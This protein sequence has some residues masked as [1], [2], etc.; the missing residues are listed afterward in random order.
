MLRTRLITGAAVGAVALLALTACA[1][2]D[3][4]SAGAPAGVETAE[5]VT[6]T[7]AGTAPVDTVT[8]SIVE[9]E[10]ATLDPASSANLIIPNLCDNL[11]AL[12]PDFSVEPGVAIRAEWTDPT[13]FVIELRD[14]VTFWDGTPLTA[15]DV[16]YSLDRNRSPE[17]QWF[18]A[19]ALVNGIEATGDHEV[20]V[21]FNAPD[22]TFRDALAGGGGAV[23]SAAFGAEAG[24]NLGT[25]DGGLMCTGPYELAA[26]GWTPGNEIVTTANPDYWNGS[27]LVSTLTY[28]FVSDA[29]TLAT[30]LT[31]GE[32]HGALNVSPSSRAA[33][34]GDGAGSLIVGPSTASY[35]FGPAT[36]DGPAA[37]PEIRRAL[38]LAIDRQQYID[39]VLSGLGE[40]Q[41]TIVPPFTFHE[42]A[43]ADV[44][45]A[46]Y[47]ALEAPEVDL[48]AAKQLVDG[49]GEDL[50]APLVL[51]V[52]AGATEFKNTAQIVQSAAKQI[53]VEI[54]INEMQASDFGA[55]FY[56][57]AAREGIDFVATQGYLETPGV[58][59]YPSL[60]MLPE[61]LGGVF[62]WSGYAN[63]EV[64]AHMQAARTATDEQTAAEEFVAA[65]Q[66]FA[67]DMLQVTLAGAYQLSYVNDELTGITTSVAVY[68]S[69]WALHL[70]GQ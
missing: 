3:S 44:Y 25:S 53:G 54:E 59:G 30:A 31:Q 66:I 17:S 18:A 39:T 63:D 49:S 36:P 67:P 46:G 51:A 43:A 23:M 62:N 10:P 61:E 27:P 35:S 16:V 5:L 42:L 65:Q 38:S 68:S 33:F 52:P 9:G 28:V 34:E 56:D 41:R 12:Q 48:E 57:P 14:D 24:D 6:S 20:T 29:S 2:R 11:L 70:G 40:P 58:L 22:S 45:Q 15:A 50:S 64:T 4:S 37:N 13:T 19:F 26:D 32:I 55:M 47:D 69:P 1:P 21:T 7:S 8:W 60:F